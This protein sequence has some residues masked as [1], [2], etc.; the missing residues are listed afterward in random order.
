VVHG[1]A[2]SAAV[3][4]VLLPSL[5]SFWVG[6]GYLIVFGVGTVLSMSAITLLLGLPFAL[7]GKFNRLNG[8]VSSVAG[9][10]SVVLGAALMS[11]IMLGT[12]LL[13]F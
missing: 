5:S 12:A 1:V 3:M 10:A 8:T 7:T 13:P 2:G 11:D 6:I 9:V 4:L